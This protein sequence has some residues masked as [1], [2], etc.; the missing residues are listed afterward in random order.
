MPGY[1]EH[2][3]FQN[4][5]AAVI[6]QETRVAL[7]L[8]SAAKPGATHGSMRGTSDAA[9]PKITRQVVG[10]TPFAYK[11]EGAARAQ[12]IYPLSTSAASTRE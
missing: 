10:G 1:R 4:A 12:V 6:S 7:M 2:K 9:T 8:L 5:Y 3:G 11:H